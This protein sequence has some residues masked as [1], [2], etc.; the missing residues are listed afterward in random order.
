MILRRGEIWQTAAQQQSGR[1]SGL[2]GMG[3]KAAALLRDESGWEGS[4][5]LVGMSAAQSSECDA[6]FRCSGI[7]VFG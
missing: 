2:V 7:R 3:G 6:G 1:C 4:T 5:L